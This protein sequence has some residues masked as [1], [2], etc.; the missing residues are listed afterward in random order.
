MSATLADLDTLLHEKGHRTYTWEMR[1]GDVYMRVIA[2][3]GID[4]PVYEWRRLGTIE[5]V[6]QQTRDLPKREPPTPGYCPRCEMYSSN[7]RIHT[8]E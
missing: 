8:C 2:S 6:E 5:E 1:G 4:D 3:G 7:M